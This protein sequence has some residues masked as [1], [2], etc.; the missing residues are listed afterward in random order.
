MEKNGKKK[1]G[2]IR[3]QEGEGKIAQGRKGKKEGLKEYRMEGRKKR[4]RQKKG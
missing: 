2:K 4:G 3:Q 1:E